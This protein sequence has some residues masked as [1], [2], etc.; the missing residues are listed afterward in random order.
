MRGGKFFSATCWSCSM[1]AQA[2]HNPRTFAR[3]VLPFPSARQAFGALLEAL[4]IGQG[5]ILLPAYI[6]WSPREGSG[7]FDPVAALGLAWSFYALDERLRLDLPSLERALQAG[8]VRVLL[9]I[10]YFGYVD[11]GYAQAVAMAREQGVFVVEDEAHALLSDLVGGVC[12]RLGDASIYSFHK[13]LPVQSGGAAV[14]NDPQSA[15]A[16]KLRGSGGC[17]PL[18]EFDLPA[19]SQRRRM[20]ATVLDRLLR[21]RVDEV[22]P[23]F[24]V[25]RSGEVPQ[26]YPVLIRKRDGARDVLYHQL[27]AAGFGAVS[28]YHTLIPQISREHFP[29]ACAVSRRILNLPV[30]QDA[31]HDELA[32]LVNKLG[33]LVKES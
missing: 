11:P 7:V 13:L 6:G 5:R 15:L 10:H 21:D 20:N 4:D 26:S 19:I 12:G 17:H 2:A 27:N 1:I 33:A 23:L 18:H 3:P 24:G 29:A 14:I 22:E 8:G 30:H 31:S 32:A 28:L 16:G 25:P 9:Q